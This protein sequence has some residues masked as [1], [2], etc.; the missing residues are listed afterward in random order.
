MTLPEDTSCEGWGIK[1]RETRN[2][3]RGKLGA[4]G[5]TRK[6][7]FPSGFELIWPLQSPLFLA[8]R[9]RP[10]YYHSMFWISCKT[11]LMRSKNGNSCYNPS[12]L[13][14]PEPF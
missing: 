7:K 10:T 8:T 6:F 4:L 2:V 1:V 12:L 5:A 9:M 13:G 3:R 14:R 11:Y